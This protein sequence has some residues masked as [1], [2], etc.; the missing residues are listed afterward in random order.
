MAALLAMPRVHVLGPWQDSGEIAHGSGT[1]DGVPRP[2]IEIHAY[3]GSYVHK[4]CEKGL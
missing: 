4:R 3:T 1:I 2:R